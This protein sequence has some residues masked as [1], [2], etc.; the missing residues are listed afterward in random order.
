MGALY[1]RPFYVDITT[2]V[3]RR[4]PALRQFTNREV[5]ATMFI[6]NTNSFKNYPRP[7]GIISTIDITITSNTT[8]KVMYRA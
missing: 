6:A 8:I 7:A 1:V 2:T 5:C 3:W 4:A